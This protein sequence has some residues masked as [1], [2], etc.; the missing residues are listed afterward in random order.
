MTSRVVLNITTALFKD[1]I[2]HGTTDWSVVL[3][4]LGLALQSALSCRVGDAIVPQY[5][6]DNQC[7]TFKDI[8]LTVTDPEHE[9]SDLLDNAVIDAQVTLWYTK[10]YT[11][12]PSVNHTVRLRTHEDAQFSAVDPVKLLLIHGSRQGAIMD[13]VIGI[14]DVLEKNYSKIEFI[15]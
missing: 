5:Y 14:E 10:G 11:N 13:A 6:E 9:G 2:Q 1:A 4:C 12:T 3:K 7:L 15:Y 8:L